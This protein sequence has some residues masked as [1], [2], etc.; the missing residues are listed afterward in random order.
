M[1]EV[2]EVAFVV[3]KCGEDEEEEGE[4]D[5]GEVG[6][7]GGGLVWWGDVGGV[8]GGVNVMHD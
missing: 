8:F 7:S 2:F 4:V 6:R 3:G 5:F 1:D